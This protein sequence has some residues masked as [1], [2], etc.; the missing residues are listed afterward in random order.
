MYRYVVQ[1]EKFVHRLMIQTVRMSDAGEYS[2]VAGSSVSKAHLIVEGRDVRI[3]EPADKTITVRHTTRASRNTYTLVLSRPRQTMMRCECSI[4]HIPIA[5]LIVRTLSF[6]F[7]VLEKQRATFEFEVNEEDLEGRWLKNGVE[8]QFSVEERF[9]YVS[10]RK[11]HRLTISETYRSDAGE[12]TFI[13]GKNKSTMNLH[14]NS[15][16]NIIFIYFTFDQKCRECNKDTKI[17]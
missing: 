5:N 1:A 4:Y 2:V 16:S 13:A 9:N 7:K 15:N 12:Y 10:I 14:V 11:I 3:T 8:I 6:S 17:Y